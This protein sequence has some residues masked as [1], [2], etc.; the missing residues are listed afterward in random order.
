L[1]ALKAR[2][3]NLIAIVDIYCNGGAKNIEF[4]DM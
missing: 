2:L 1:T 3:V 4:D